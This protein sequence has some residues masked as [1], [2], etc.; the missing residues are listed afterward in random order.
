MIRLLDISTEHHQEEVGSIISGIPRKSCPPFYEKFNILVPFLIN[1]RKIKNIDSDI[2]IY[3]K[4]GP[5][6]DSTLQ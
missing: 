5:S 4:K 1:D 3:I 6:H 2:M